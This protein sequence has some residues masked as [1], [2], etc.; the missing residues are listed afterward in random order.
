MT[1]R[2]FVLCLIV[3]MVATMW[4]Q[5][6]AQSG[7][8]NALTS[9]SPCLNYI[10]GSSSTPSAS[11]CSQLSSV[12]QSSPQC[13]CSVLNGGGSTFGITINQTL[14][15]SLP[16][17]CKVQTPPVSQCQAGNGATSPWAAPVGSPS[18]SSAESPQA[19]ITPSASDFPSGAGSKTVPST[20]SGL[21]SDGN[22]IK[23]P[24]YLVLYLLITIVSCGLTF[25]MF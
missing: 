1:F 6:A 23:V 25:T 4:T 11:C 3:V 24:S 12:V 21:S 15:L 14:A 22:A 17:A 10:M 8:T 19:S 16:G 7:C 13:L 2:G 5:N 9:L 20:D 18:D